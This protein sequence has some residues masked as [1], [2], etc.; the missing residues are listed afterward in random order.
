MPIELRAIDEDELVPFCRA[1]GTGFGHI[2]VSDAAIA[3]ERSVI[4]LDRTIAGFDGDQ[5]VST[6]GAY[7]FAMTV[8][9]GG[10]VPVAGVT[11]VSVLA[12]HRRRGVLRS[13][14]THQLDDVVARGEPMA[15]LNAS[16]SSIYGRFG[17]GLAQFYQSWKLDALRCSFHTPVRDDLRLRLLAKEEAAPVLQPIYEAW[18]P[19]RPGAL[20]HSDPWW[21]CVLGDHPSWKGGGKIFVV[22]CEAGDGNAAS[23]GY[24]IY[25][26]DQKGPMPGHWTLHVR[27]L[28]ASDPDVSARLWRYLL[29]VDLIGTVVAPVVPL[30]DPLRWRLDDP[31][32]VQTTD[33]RDFLYVRLLDVERS[34]SARRYAADHSITLAIRDAFRPDVAGCYRVVGGP[35][36]A[37]C[38]R[39]DDGASVYLEL[40]IAEVGSLYLGGVR[41]RD[42]AAAGR[43]IERVPGAL[44]R[45][46]AFFP[47][48]VAP[49]CVTR[50]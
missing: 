20:S 43:I 13:M 28:V 26:V 18:R 22:A 24:A 50:F 11:A 42:L 7:S 15:I 39:V 29:D 10:T 9:G 41:A 46:D 33:V 49:F 27:D 19:T 36:G 3:H 25:S 17:Y 1:E 2:D 35:D 16:E 4:E 12:T 14:M 32:Q 47:W 30:D 8:P 34:L 6:A 45:A 21:G 44:D 23:G 48:P 38:T 37:S 40:D 31:R 5:I